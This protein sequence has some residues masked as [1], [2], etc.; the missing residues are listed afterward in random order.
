[1]ALNGRVQDR[2]SNWKFEQA[3]TA[4]AAQVQAGE[5]IPT[6]QETATVNALA[7]T[8]GNPGWFDGSLADVVRAA[9]WFLGVTD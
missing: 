7:D 6:Q 5:G 8:F 2:L 9:V 1:M 3:R 4:L